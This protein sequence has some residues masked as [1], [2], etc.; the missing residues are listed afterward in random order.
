MLLQKALLYNLVVNKKIPQMFLRTDA[1]KEWSPLQAPM[2]RAMHSLVDSE[3]VERGGCN[4]SGSG[5]GIA[6]FG[7]LRADLEN[8]LLP[9][10]PRFEPVMP[11]KN[12]TEKSD[13]Q[14]KWHP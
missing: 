10:K 7:K 13:E 11:L 4:R 1:E 8:V 12:A 14:S 3:T 2:R 9:W 6:S 5:W